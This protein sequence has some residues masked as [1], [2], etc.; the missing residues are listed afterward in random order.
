MDTQNTGY[1]DTQN[2]G[3]IGIQNTG[4]IGIQNTE[5]RVHGYTEYRVTI[6]KGTIDFIVFLEWHVRFY[7]EDVVIFIFKSVDF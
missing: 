3:Y 6:F 5:Y 2:T 1:M 7:E 4:Y